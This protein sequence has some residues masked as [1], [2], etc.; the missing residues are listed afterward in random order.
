MVPNCYKEANHGLCTFHDDDNDAAGP[1]DLPTALTVSS[2]YYFYNLG[3]LFWAQQAKYGE[4]PIQNV[5]ANYGLTEPTNIDLPEEA[6]SRVDSPEVRKQLHAEDPVAFPYT[7]WYTGDN[8]ELAF[9][10]GT[11]ALTPIALA[12]AYA[13]FANGGTRYAPEVAAA[14][15]N[16]HGQIIQRYT[17]RVIGHVSLP[18]SVRDPILEG[19]SGVVQSPKG[20]G[21]PAFQEYFHHSLAAYPIAGKTGTA[22]NKPGVEPNSL[23]VGFGPTNHPDY[24]VIC[25]IEEGGYGADA[26]AP[27]VAKTF[28]YLVSHPVPALTLHPALTLPTGK[29]AEKS[30]NA[31]STTTTA[32]H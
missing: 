5:A 2:D 1:I 19:L 11:T 14:V 12:N 25:V 23:F 4:T 29:K 24:V 31:S 9:G 13:T 6:T 32:A 26:S 18:G 8:I 30:K 10:Q 15:L 27:V 28:N 7:T 22:S 17:P 21:Y 3:Y 20:T 16:P